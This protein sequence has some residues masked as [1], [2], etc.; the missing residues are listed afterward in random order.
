MSFVPWKYLEELIGII[1][2]QIVVRQ[3]LINYSEVIIL[4]LVNSNELVLSVES[5]ILNLIKI[6]FVTG[7]QRVWDGVTSSRC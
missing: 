4:L 6:S 3:N 5:Q 7:K 1:V 2:R